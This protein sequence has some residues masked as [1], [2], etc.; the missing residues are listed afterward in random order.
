MSSDVKDVN[1]VASE[2]VPIDLVTQLWRETKQWRSCLISF[3]TARVNR[4]LNRMTH[5]S[6][7]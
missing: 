1:E 6:F 3:R 7:Q 4:I 2:N 5:E